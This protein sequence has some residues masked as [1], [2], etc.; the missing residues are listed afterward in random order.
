MN[1]LEEGEIQEEQQQQVPFEINQER[2]VNLDELP[3][4]LIKLGWRK[5]LSKRENRFYYFNYLTNQSFW[6][7]NEIYSTMVSLVYYS[8]LDTSS[9][10]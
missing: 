9:F 2:S 7:L 5:H 4:Q 3:S 10:F 6:S 8:K 1:H